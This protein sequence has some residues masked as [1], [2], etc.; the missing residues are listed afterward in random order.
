MGCGKGVVCG[1]VVWFVRRGGVVCGE[2]LV[3]VY[4]RRGDVWGGVVVG[5]VIG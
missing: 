5:R 2:G 3:C 4:V 1:G